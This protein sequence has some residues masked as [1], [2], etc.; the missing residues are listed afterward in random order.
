VSTEIKDVS[1]EFPTHELRGDGRSA[2][3]IVGTPSGAR[4]VAIVPRADFLAAVAVECD[5]IVIPRTDLPEVAQKY[6]EYHAGT[7]VV[8]GGTTAEEALAAAR[9]WLAL[10]EH[11]T[12]H[13]PLSDLGTAL[14]E[15]AG[16]DREKAE[17]VARLLTED[18]WSR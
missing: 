5:A 7:L 15:R 1:R 18:G 13:P 4:W 12:A 3:F 8:E 6:G 2:T 14:V 16:M 11:L 17:H 10:A 9:E